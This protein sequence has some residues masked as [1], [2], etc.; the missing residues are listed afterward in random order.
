MKQSILLDLG[1]LQERLMGYVT[2]MSYC[3]S[4][5]CVKADAMSLLGIEL[6]DGDKVLAIEDLAYVALHNKEGDDDKIDLIPKGDSSDIEILSAGVAESYPEFIQSIETEETDED[7]AQKEEMR[8]T[9]EKQ[10]G[11]KV[12]EAEKAY[13]LRLTMPEVNDDRKKLLE[14]AVTVIHDTA[15]LQMDAVLTYYTA[16]ITAKLVGE[17][18]ETAEA[19]KGKLEELKKSYDDMREKL[20]DD[21]KKEIEDGNKRYHERHDKE[22]EDDEE[23]KKKILNSLKMS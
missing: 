9:V 14:D 16:S 10:F 15:K 18:E 7:L 5:Y 4:Q 17:T 11:M 6:H 13:Y 8:A 2:N 3:Y 22:S 12:P 23:Y 21:K 1:N 19:I 20:T